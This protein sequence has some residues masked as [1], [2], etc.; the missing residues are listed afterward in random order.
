[1]DF[2]GEI[3][4]FLDEKVAAYNTSDF[5]ENDPVCIPHRY[6]LKEDIEIAGF[7]AATISWGN[8][9]SIV[10]N[11]CFMLELLGES[12]YDFVM[13]HTRRQLQSL[14]QFVHRTFNGTDY[15]CFIQSLKHLY[16]V[17]GGLEAVFNRYAEAD[18]LQKAI[19]R[20][21]QLFFEKSTS[22]RSKKHISDPLGWIWESGRPFIRHNFLV[23]WTFIP[24]MLHENLG[25][26]KENKMM[27]VPC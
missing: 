13:S 27:L 14:D 11:G 19:H 20:F 5:I 25:S 2:D 16:Q 15:Q 21:K 17:H 4:A 7:L 3:K 8:R 6:H 26:S 12:P 24:E 22:E 10:K 1:M 23:R 18:S 9:K